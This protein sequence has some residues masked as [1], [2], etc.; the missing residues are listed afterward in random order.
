MCLPGELSLRF[1]P[2]S[3]LNHRRSCHCQALSELAVAA[4]MATLPPASGS[5]AA[6]WPRPLAP[7]ASRSLAPRLCCL[8]L[9]VRV[10]SAPAPLVATC[11]H[12]LPRSPRM[13]SLLRPPATALLRSCPASHCCICRCRACLRTLPLSPPPLAAADA[14]FG[15]P[16]MSRCHCLPLC[17]VR[18]R[19][20]PSTPRS[21]ARSQIPATFDTDQPRKQSPALLRSLVLTWPPRGPPLCCCQRV[22]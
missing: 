3:A 18:V 16:W 20:S 8:P 5:L 11:V 17:A 6:P 10:A 15:C 22:P 13:H 7:P 14:D 19:T 12:P 21:G 4:P 2:I 1:L 9:A